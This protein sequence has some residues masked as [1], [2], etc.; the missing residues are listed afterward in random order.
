LE[1]RLVITV[2]GQGVQVDICITGC[3]F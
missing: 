3:E 1:G 2:N